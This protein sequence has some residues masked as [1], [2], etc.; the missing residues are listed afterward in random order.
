M[1]GVREQVMR[2]GMMTKIRLKRSIN[3]IGGVAVFLIPLLAHV[4]QNIHRL[5]KKMKNRSF[6]SCVCLMRTDV[7]SAVASAELND[8]AGAQ[9]TGY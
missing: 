1:N 9:K 2:H 6:L 5:K 4:A 3:R 7:I 8:V